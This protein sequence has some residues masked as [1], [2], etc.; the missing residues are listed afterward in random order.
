VEDGEKEPPTG[1]SSRRC[2]MMSR[3]ITLIYSLALT[4]REAAADRSRSKCTRAE[5]ML[6][7]LVRRF[8]RAASDIE[9]YNCYKG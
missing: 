5:N 8:V 9:C 7:P 2:P 3:K 6:Q 4:D 1:L